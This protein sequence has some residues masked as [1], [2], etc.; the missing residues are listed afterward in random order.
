M[1]LAGFIEQSPIAIIRLDK[2]G[3]IVEGNQAFHSLT[4]A[5][6][7]NGLPFPFLNMVATGKR[8]EAKAVM[9]KA[10]NGQVPAAVQVFDLML[11]NNT[12]II[13]SVY[14]SLITNATSESQLILHLIDI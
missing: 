11:P 12:E 6:I 5:A 4:Q 2:S 1:T 9:E 8:D 7:E 3:N 13:V 14:F 10:L